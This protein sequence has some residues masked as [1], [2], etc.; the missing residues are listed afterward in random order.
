MKTFQVLAQIFSRH[1]NS[2]TLLSVGLMSLHLISCSDNPLD[3]TTECSEILINGSFE[4]FRT[5]PSSNGTRA[6]G[7]EEGPGA[8]HRSIDIF[9][10]HS[11][12]MGSQIPLDGKNFAGISQG[13]HPSRYMNE[14]MMG[15]LRSQVP[16]GEERSYTITA[17]FATGKNSPRPYPSDMELLLYNSQTGEE[18]QVI[19]AHVPN[20]Q[21]WEK[22]SGSI[23]TTK[24]YDRLVI[25]GIN[26]YP[27]HRHTLGYLYV[28]NVSVEECSGDCNSQDDLL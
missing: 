7:W 26:R 13:H 14:S 19:N 28:D 17:W 24:R 16:D 6:E 1:K 27:E 20:T 15:T 12:F 9:T 23:T 22:V 4:V 21:Q 2:L 18:L 3:S 8:T 25:H 5:S 10:S 11:N